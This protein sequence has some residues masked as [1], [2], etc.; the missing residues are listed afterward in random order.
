MSEDTWTGRGQENPRT[1][2]HREPRA[3]GALAARDAFLLAHP[4]L[5]VL[6]RSAPAP[7]FVLVVVD[8]HT[9]VVGAHALGVGDALVLGRHDQAGLVLPAAAISLRHLAALV[10]SGDG[11]TELR[12][13]DLRTGVPFLTEDGEP[14]GGVLADGPLYISLDEYALWFLPAGFPLPGDPERAWQSLPAREF[15]ERAPVRPVPSLRPHPRVLAA[16]P[17]SVTRFT[18]PLLLGEGREPELG[19]GELRISAKGRKE[20]R[21]VSAERLEQ[22]LLLGRYERCGLVIETSDRI[23]RVHL[24]LLRIGLEVWAVDLASTNGVT[25]DGAP[26]SAGPLKDED[27]LILAREVTVEWRRTLHAEA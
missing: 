18:A 19:W 1:I 23:S 4:R 5:A 3:P 27:A 20:R 21:V 10:R 15:L 8:R 22:G 16:E 25:R 24:A 11:V 17:T 6:C 14:A 9:Q 2:F 26:F 13:W 12:L 7:G